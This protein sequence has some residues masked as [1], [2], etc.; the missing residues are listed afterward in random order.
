M[1]VGAS[2]HAL[3][4]VSATE[5]M[6]GGLIIDVRKD[7]AIGPDETKKSCFFSVSL[8]T[9][10]QEVG[11]CVFVADEVTGGNLRQ[12]FVRLYWEDTLIYSPVDT[13]TREHVLTSLLV[14]TPTPTP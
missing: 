10:L 11:P 7:I 5:P 9:D 1:P 8:R 14:D 13:E 6:T 3:V 2:V 12:Y 4:T